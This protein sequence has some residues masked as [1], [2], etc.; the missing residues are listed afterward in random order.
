MHFFTGIFF[1]VQ[2]CD[3]DLLRPPLD[4]VARFV[5]FCSHDL[6][7]AVDRKG[8]I[9]LRDLIALWQVRVEVIFAGKNRLMIDA[10][11]ESEGRTGA[12]FNSSA[13]YDRKCAR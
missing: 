11:S 10:Q 9:E 6:K 4:G 8:L 7:L 12:E 3:V 5:T 13:V 2:P 1:E